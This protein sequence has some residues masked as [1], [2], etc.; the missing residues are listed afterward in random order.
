ML[1][2]RSFTF[3]MHRRKED[4]GAYYLLAELKTG[5]QENVLRIL[6]SQEAFI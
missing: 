2:K 6:S 3:V 1:I 5:M 4:Y